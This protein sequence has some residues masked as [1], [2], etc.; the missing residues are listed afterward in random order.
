MPSKPSLQDILKFLDECEEKANKFVAL[1][2][3][4]REDAH[5]FTP[6]T[7]SEKWSAFGKP[8]LSKLRRYMNFLD[9]EAD[10]KTCSD[11]CFADEV[12]EFIV[13]SELHHPS[14]FAQDSTP[15]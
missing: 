7:N 13:C 10:E 1:S 15:H 6:F 8:T 12:D 5:P 2:L 14:L 11:D 9:N 4:N 3:L